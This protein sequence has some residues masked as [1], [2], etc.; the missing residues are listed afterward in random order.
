[1]LHPI[2]NRFALPHLGFGVGLRS[3]HYPHLLSEWPPVDWFEII[4]ENFMDMGGRPM[5]ML[6]EVAARYPM[7]M[8]GVSMSIGSTDP[9]DIDYLTKLK[10]LA[11]KIKAVWV[12]DHLCWTGVAHR[13]AHDLLPLPYNEPT[14]R[15]VI[16]RIKR[17]QDFLGR[18]LVLENPSTYVEF[19]DSDMSEWEFMARMAEHTHKGTHIID[20]HSDYVIEAVWQLYAQ[21]NV[22]SGG[23]A[24][25]LE[26][27]DNIPEFSIVHAEV[28]KAKALLERPE[29]HHV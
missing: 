25:L 4:S 5:F 28:L 3:T 11:E 15:H 17:V 26:W 21:A 20:T 22:Y 27:D 13:N 7:V 10:A 1:M 16:E 12:S 6:E 29:G 8:H 2:P 23:R 14:L 18:P 9:L 19:R 24:T